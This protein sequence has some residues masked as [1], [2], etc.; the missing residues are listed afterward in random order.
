MSEI[1]I[2]TN[3]KSFLQTN[4]NLAMLIFPYKNLITSTHLIF[5]EF[6]IPW[7]HPNLE[8]AFDLSLSSS[9]V[10]CLDFRLGLRYFHRARCPFASVVPVSSDESIVGRSNTYCSRSSC[11]CHTSTPPCLEAHEAVPEFFWTTSSN[12][13]PPI[14]RCKTQNR[15]CTR[16]NSRN[17][18][19]SYSRQRLRFCLIFYLKNF[20][21][22]IN[23]LW[24]F[25][26][27][28]LNRNWFS[29]S[30]SFPFEFSFIKFKIF[31]YLHFFHIIL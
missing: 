18:C 16:C 2:L 7:V 25:F 14:R 15:N 31:K 3:L 22:L 10:L 23:L 13:C 11:R 1:W 27:S 6:D 21:T 17:H 4:K 9:L 28:T 20:N 24:Y 26:E 19:C 29:N 8:K 12:I 5:I 30:I